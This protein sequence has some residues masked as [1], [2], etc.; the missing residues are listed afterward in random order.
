M[1]NTYC[2]NV[3][4]FTLI[5]ITSSSLCAHPTGN[6]IVV[7]EYALW[8]YIN[9][10]DDE[11]HHACVMM[12]HPKTGVDIFLQ[13]E[14]PASDYMLFN[15]EDQLFIIERRHIEE[16]QGF[17]SRILTAKI[18]ESPVEVWPWFL[19]K[20][21]VGE[22]G[23]LMNTESQI[24]FGKYPNVYCMD[25]G[26]EPVK[27]FESP[28]EINKIRAV[29]ENL[30][31]LFGAG[32]CWLTDDRGT[33]KKEWKNLID[34]TVENAPLNRNQLFDADY[35]NH[36]LLVA[37]WGK[38]SFYLIDDQGR[39]STIV[40]QQAPMVPHWVGF[41]GKH[42]LLFSSKLVFTGETPRPKLVLHRSENEQTVIWE[43]E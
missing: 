22:G 2:W 43:V 42:S 14:H 34:E 8:S 23:F 36:Q 4:L 10:I 28:G 1:R 12:W 29:E 38:R 6:L 5:S 35:Q 24:V 21:R 11:E 33:I 30:I 7:G 13:S 27:Y 26:E 20:W 37:Y 32:T 18:G 39:F 9:P 19:D 31:L 16:A 15:K 25:K 3:F 41:Y 17:E 40:Q